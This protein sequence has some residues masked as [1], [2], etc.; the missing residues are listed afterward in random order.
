MLLSPRTN[1]LTSLFKEVRAFKACLSVMKLDTTVY[2]YICI[3]VCLC[4]SYMESQLECTAPCGSCLH[5]VVSLLL[6][7]GRSW[8][9]QPPLRKL[10]ASHLARS[11]EEAENRQRRSKEEENKKRKKKKKEKKQ[12]RSKEEAKKNPRRNKEER[13]ETKKKR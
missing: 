7:A 9:S 1:G 2:I 11:K 13:A 5:A 4:L 12:R 10:Q 3:C 6:V 8:R